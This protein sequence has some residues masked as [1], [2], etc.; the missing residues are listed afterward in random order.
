MSTERIGSISDEI[1]FT[2]GGKALNSKAGSDNDDVKEEAGCTYWIDLGPNKQ[3]VLDVSI[4]DNN[5]F[6]SFDSC[7]NCNPTVT[8][9]LVD[10]D[11]FHQNCLFQAVPV[12]NRL[13]HSVAEIPIK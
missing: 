4:N 6:A 12:T 13:D 11:S 5:D 8:C 3:D 7:S 9:R 10:D 2:V 1:V